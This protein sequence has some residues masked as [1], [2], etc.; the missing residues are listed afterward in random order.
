ME[1]VT[2]KND[3]IVFCIAAK[4]FPD[5]V[6]EAHQSLHAI[7]PPA[8]GR[9]YYGISFS[10]QDEI[11]Y[12]AAVGFDNKEEANGQDLEKFVIR[13]GKYASRVIKNFMDDIPSIGRTFRELLSD[14]RI[15]Q[16]GYCIED[17]FNNQ[18]VRCLVK[19]ADD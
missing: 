18:D 17:Y 19:L 8:P 16:H 6:Q 3:R 2:F 12:K 4:Q 13:K 15:D 1:T 11:T 5:G 7:F 10:N 14:A 9:H